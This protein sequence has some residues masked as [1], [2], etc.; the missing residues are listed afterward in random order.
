MFEDGTQCQVCHDAADH[1]EDHHVGCGGN[2][3][4]IFR[5]NALRDAIFSAAQFAALAPRREVPCVIPSSYS[6]PAYSSLPSWVR[7]QHAALDVIIIFTMQPAT[8]NGTASTQGHALLFIEARKLSTCEA[9]CTA[10]EFSFVPT[11]M[12]FLGGMSA[13]AVNT[14]AG[15]GR[16]L[17]QQLGIQTVDSIRHLFQKCSI[18]VWRENTAMWLRRLPTFS[19]SVD[20]VF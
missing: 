6:Q 20:G 7:G 1:F 9:A 10:V 4:R 13:L 16:L 19:P 5:H 14:L 11:V 8:I 12:E 17:G 2:G 15:I 3:D 18:T